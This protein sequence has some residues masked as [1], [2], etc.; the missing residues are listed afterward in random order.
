MPKEPG[1]NREAVE[2]ASVA[3]VEKRGGLIPAWLP[4]VLAVVTFLAYLPSLDS[5]F[6]YD[7]RKEIIEEGFVASL[8]NLPAVLTLKVLGTNL[9][10]GPRPGQLLYLM[11]LYAVCGAHPFGFHL[12][13]ILLHAAN[14]ALVLVVLARLLPGEGTKRDRWTMRLAATATTLLFA[15][16]PIA[17][18]PVAEISYSSTLLVTFFTL[19]SLL[20]ATAFRAKMSWRAL[21]MGTIG[22]ASVFAAVCCKESGVI[23][24]PLLVVYWFLYSRGEA[25]RP[26]F[27]F[28][29]ASVAMTV[30][31]LVARF[32]LAPQ[33]PQAPGYLGGSFVEVF[34]IQ[35]P[36]WAFMMGKLFWPVGLAADYNVAD[37]GGPPLWFSLLF[38]AL[39][40]GAQAGLAMRS[41]LGAMGV[42]TFW[43]G[44]V[45]VSN[46][47]PLYHPLADRYL[48]FPLA[49]L[50]IQLLA[51]FLVIRRAWAG[52]ATAVVLVAML[53]LLWLTV[54]RQAVFANEIALWSDAV[55][56]DPRSPL[57]RDYLG[58]ALVAAGRANEGMAQ[59]QA[60]IA[61]DPDYAG[62]HT[63]LGLVLEQK[64]QLDAA[65]AEY[66]EALKT[67]PNQPE[68]HNDLGQLL[69]QQGHVDAAVE[70][71]EKALGLSPLLA[72]AHNNLGVALFQKKRT[73]EAIAQFEEAVRLNPSYRD[74]QDNL[75]KVNAMSAK[76]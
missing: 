15:L 13:S 14:V 34:A 49:G 21:V 10:L 32:S 6:V 62:A 65:V 42:V 39:V 57:A 27:L 38:L 20:V 66:R 23:A 60:A 46:F 61:L 28:L 72:V 24:A 36:L 71:F 45:T 40:L 1:K 51:T 25:K 11:L 29:G 26:W 59:Y 76:R 68:G 41:R 5:D 30:A 43:G 8:A 2:I 55:Q 3:P 75:A 47:I 19:V 17:V 73:A 54:S 18:E 12:A 16:H 64:G 4:L 56:V 9:L 33:D 37:I 7:A 44:L 22:M 67:A 58:A 53:P 35:P 48:Y 70:E 69:L 63:N 50:A 31:F 74:A 52:A